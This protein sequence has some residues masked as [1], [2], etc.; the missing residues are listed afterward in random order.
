MARLVT[1]GELTDGRADAGDATAPRLARR[2]AL[3]RQAME[4]QGY[5][6]L[7]I[8]GR[9]VISQ[10]GYLEYLTGYCPI[11]R[12]S[13]AVLT[14]D[15]GPRAISPTTADRWYARQAEPG[16][17]VRVAGQGDVVAEWNELAA[18]IAATLHDFGVHAGRVGIVG[19]RG[20][21]PLADYEALVAAL[22]N[23][24]FED[25]TRLVGAIKARKDEDDIAELRRTAAIADRGWA[26]G[27]ARLRPGASAREVGAAMHEAVRAEG[28]RDVLIFVSADPYFLGIPSDRRFVA[29][30]LV[31]TY[32]EIVGPTG[33]W[34]EVGG[35]VA[36]GEIDDERRRL[37]DASVRASLDAAARLRPGGT[38]ADVAGVIDRIAREGRYE[39]GIWHGHGVGVDHDGPVITA[40]DGTPLAPGMVISVHPNFTTPDER[41]GASTVGTYVVRDDGEAERLSRVPDTLI[42]VSV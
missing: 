12:L 13:Y 8:A 26:A 1:R 6:A 42:E 41:L 7:V 38:A 16:I 28:A 5:D 11:V 15:R 22:P 31:T 18:G 23:V 24:V 30:D 4:D 2:I 40:G 10:Y 27:R 20:I 17:E 32:V 25:A 9:G 35:L 34:V 14:R 19:L 29:G 39:T 33:Y 36:L 21:V 3:T 37:A